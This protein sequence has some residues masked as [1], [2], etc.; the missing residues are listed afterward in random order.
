MGSRCILSAQLL[1]RISCLTGRLQLHY[2]LPI[3]VGRR[4][5]Q[6]L[7]ALRPQFA[8]LRCS[9]LCQIFEAI[10]M[11]DLIVTSILGWSSRKIFGRRKPLQGDYEGARIFCCRPPNT[12]SAQ[13]PLDN[14]DSLLL[15]TLRY[16]KSLYAPGAFFL[17]AF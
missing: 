9:G 13:I 16:D 10:E 11:N 5:L 15:S 17:G 14:D 1:E 4:H 6:V 2:R 12:A 8:V 3:Y 7:D